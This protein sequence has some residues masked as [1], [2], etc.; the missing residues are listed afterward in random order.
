MKGNCL[1]MIRKI[2]KWIGIVLG[3]LVGLLVLVFA[4]L[5][6]IGGARWNRIRWN[7]DFPF[8]S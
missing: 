2:L 7:Y 1:A 8:D 3:S 5:Y 6:M 4:I